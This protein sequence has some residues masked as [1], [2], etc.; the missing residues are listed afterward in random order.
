MYFVFPTPSIC[1]VDFFSCYVMLNLEY[2]ICI[3]IEVTKGEFA[4]QQKISFEDALWKSPK[5]Q[6]GL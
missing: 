3:E 5:A 1:R 4:L 6:N 2:L